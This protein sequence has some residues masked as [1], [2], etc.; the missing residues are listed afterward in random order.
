M[1]KEYIGITE[2]QCIHGGFRHSVTRIEVEPLKGCI[3]SSNKTA[4]SLVGDL[5]RKGAAAWIMYK[6]LFGVFNV[7][8][9]SG[10]SNLPNS[11]R[12]E[13]GAAELAKT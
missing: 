4:L 7:S 2:R 5:V 1:L 12:L 10:A 3:G 8:E 9:V 6:T 11:G 13:L